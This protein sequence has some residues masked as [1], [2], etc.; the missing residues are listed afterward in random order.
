M[1]KQ[2]TGIA[3]KFKSLSDPNR[4]YI[5]DQLVKGEKCACDL[6]ELLNVS[7]STLSHHM[8]IL[9]DAGIVV[10]RREGK[11]A[12]YSISMQGVQELNNYINRY[13]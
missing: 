6:L 7:Q 9:T 10:I 8:K 5:L 1:D 12:H 3:K 13:S 4:L 2:Y 11:W